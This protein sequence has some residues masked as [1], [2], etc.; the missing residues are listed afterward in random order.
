[1][2]AE[3]DG[4]AGLIVTVSNRLGDPLPNAI[5][6]PFEGAGQDVQKAGE[7]IQEAAN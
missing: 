5:D 3:Q 4:A 1:M 2:T 6:T 7:A